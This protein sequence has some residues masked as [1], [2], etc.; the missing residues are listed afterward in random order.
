[1][2]NEIDYQPIKKAPT[3]GIGIRYYIGE[4]E[5][6]ID[7][8]WLDICSWKSL[9]VVGRTNICEVLDTF[10]PNARDTIPITGA[11]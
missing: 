4:K 1:M 9:F 2:I 10:L 7:K 3:I 5:H 8:G 11:T 6:S